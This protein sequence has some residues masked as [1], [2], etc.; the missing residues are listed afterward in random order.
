MLNFTLGCGFQADEKI[1]LKEKLKIFKE[2]NFLMVA[3]EHSS[4]FIQSTKSMGFIRGTKESER[5]WLPAY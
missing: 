3:I 1:L 5:N 4:F 2:T